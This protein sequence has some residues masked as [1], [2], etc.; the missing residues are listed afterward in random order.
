MPLSAIFFA[1]RT[2]FDVDP[3]RRIHFVDSKDGAEVE[4]DVISELIMSNPTIELMVLV[5]D[6]KWGKT[7]FHTDFWLINIGEFCL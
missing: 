3:D 1:V 5:D 2:K 6:Q 4:E 7:Y